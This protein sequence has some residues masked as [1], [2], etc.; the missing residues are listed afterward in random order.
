MVTRPADTSLLRSLSAGTLG[1][2]LGVFLGLVPMGDWAPPVENALEERDAAE[3][4]VGRLRVGAVQLLD[5]MGLRGEVTARVK[6][7]E[8]LAAKALRKGISED[9]VEDRMGVRLIV[10][11]EPDCYAVMAALQTQYP[12]LPGSFDD[13][14]RHPK[15][16]GYQSLQAAL[17]TPDGL[18][19]FQVRTHEMHQFAET[20][21]A[22]HG[23]YKANQRLLAD[24]VM[25]SALG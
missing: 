12:V 22:A 8:S 5:T 1:P 21:P 17:F 24:A 6:S 16:N 23:Q 15:A 10:D 14:I 9:Q 20:G 11:S 18:A 19:E 25:M 3:V 4:A 7:A 13:Y 2:A